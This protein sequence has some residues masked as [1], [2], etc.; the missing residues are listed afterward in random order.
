MIS[1]QRTLIRD[2][3]G[4]SAV[5]F[6]ILLP[7]LLLLIF[8]TIEISLYL[9]NRQVITNATREGV[10]VGITVRPP[11][12][13]LTA[14]N[15]EIEN[16]V[17]QYAEDHLVTF[18]TQDMLNVAVSRRCKDETSGDWV[19]CPSLPDLPPG[20]C[21]DFACALIVQSDFVYDFLFLS[22]AG[23]GPTNIQA[24]ARMGME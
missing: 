5:E 15:T 7:L 12:R 13:N 14:E 23:F 11:A 1:K 18:G 4:A 10:R 9:F 3:K 6:A 19:D 21:F 17:R 2:Q 24:V 20:R 16:I 22:T 8:G